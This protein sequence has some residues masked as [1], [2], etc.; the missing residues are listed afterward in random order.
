MNA[1]KL[2]TSGA[3]TKIY[4]V[5]T[6][7]VHNPRGQFICASVLILIYAEYWSNVP[8][9]SP[10]SAVYMR[11]WMGLALVQIMACRLFGAKPLS[12]PM[13]S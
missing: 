8:N 4:T 5:F 10:P 1:A 2:A 12:I 3:A 13:L 7:F 6:S 11:Q 9:G